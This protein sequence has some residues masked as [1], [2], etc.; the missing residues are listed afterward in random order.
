[1]CIIIF[2][3][4]ISEMDCLETLYIKLWLHVDLEAYVCKTKRVLKKMIHL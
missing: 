1:M 3:Y 4:S 2:P